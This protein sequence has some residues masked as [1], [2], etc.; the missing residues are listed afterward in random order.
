MDDAQAIENAHAR[1]GVHPPR[2]GRAHG[3]AHR[4]NHTMNQTAFEIE[5]LTTVIEEARYRGF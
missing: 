3:R 2:D 5:R 4:L 1:D